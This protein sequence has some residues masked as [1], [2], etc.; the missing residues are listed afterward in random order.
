MLPT[1]FL[2]GISLL[3]AAAAVLA[4]PLSAIKETS[5]Y[6]WQLLVALHAQRTF[7][8]LRVLF[9]LALACSSHFLRIGW[10]DRE[11]QVATGLGFYSLVSLAGTLVHSYQSY[12]WPYSFVDVAISCSYLL[13]L[14]Y[15]IYSFAQQEAARRAMTPQMQSFLLGMAG[16]LR[17]QRAHHH[18]LTR[19]GYRK[20]RTQ[21]R[22]QNMIGRTAPIALAALLAGAAAALAQAPA[23]IVTL[24]H[25]APPV[26]LSNT[27]QRT[28][29]ASKIGRSYDLFISLPEDYAASKQSY[30]V[31]YVLDG[32]HFPLMAFLQ[33]NNVYS[34][35][36]PPVIIVNIGQSPASD[37]MALRAQDFS[38]TPIPQS[39]GGGGGGAAA[40]LDFFEHELIPFIDRTYRTNPADRALLGHSMG[41]K[42]ALYALEQRPGLFQR[43]VAASPAL[44]LDDPLMDNAARHAL[45][46]DHAPVRLDLSVGSDDELGFT[47]TTSTFAKMLDELNPKGLDYRFTVYQGEN[48]NSVRLVSFPAGLYWVY[49]SAK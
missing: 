13:S 40:F 44:F 22:I 20:A 38:P 48:H 49:R 30:P 27:E 36:V 26:A 28:I 47:K 43:I 33:E 29:A 4:W 1:E 23:P 46:A 37:A 5:G 41:G 9:F 16:M 25:P 39:L 19:T 21:A 15:R 11:L 3:I 18:T 2:F 42:F 45:S 6:P 14:V 31:L 17:Y 32:W 7:A 8:I 12:G 24:T 35:R 10:R 34:R